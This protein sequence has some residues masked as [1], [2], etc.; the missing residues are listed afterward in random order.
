RL[1]ASTPLHLRALGEAGL[2]FPEVDLIVSATAPLDPAPARPGRS[3]VRAPLLE[4][5][6]STETCVFATRR[7]AQQDVWKIYDGISL[8]TGTD[9]TQVSAACYERPPRR[10]DP[11]C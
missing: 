3:R 8:E 4:M 9:S 11:L 2:T 1:L 7:T 5:F 10:I 6:G